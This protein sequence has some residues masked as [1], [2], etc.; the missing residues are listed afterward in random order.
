[1]RERH[2]SNN[3]QHLFINWKAKDIE[4]SIFITACKDFANVLSDTRM[5]EKDVDHL[6]MPCKSVPVRQS[7]HNTLFSLHVKRKKRSK[8]SHDVL[9]FIIPLPLSLNIDSLINMHT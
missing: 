3:Y 7:G 2:W 8:R 5:S 1:M 6:I 4:H 9:R